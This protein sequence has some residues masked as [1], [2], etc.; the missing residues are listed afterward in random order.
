MLWG[1]TSMMPA[2][3]TLSCTALVVYPV[4]LPAGMVATPRAAEYC[5]QRRRV[6]PVYTPVFALQ[7]RKALTTVAPAGTVIVA[8]LEFDVKPVTELFWVMTKLSLTF[9]ALVLDAACRSAQVPL[10]VAVVAEHASTPLPAMMKSPLT[11]A[12]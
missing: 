9:C 2:P 5:E 1:A 12:W 6:S 10:V 4:A 8:L 11:L 3:P 7:V